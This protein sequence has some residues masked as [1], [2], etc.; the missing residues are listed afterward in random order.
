MLPISVL[1][2]IFYYISLKDTHHIQDVSNHLPYLGPP[3]YSNS[4][5]KIF[6]SVFGVQKLI[7]YLYYYNTHCYQVTVLKKLISQRNK[8]IKEWMEIRV[9]PIYAGVASLPTWG[10]TWEE[11]LEQL[12][13]QRTPNVGCGVRGM[14]LEMAL[15]YI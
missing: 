14:V 10:A 8:I 2:I 5:I 13:P 4:I 9:H 6:S 15:D 12:L 1:S 11:L 3:I 7:D